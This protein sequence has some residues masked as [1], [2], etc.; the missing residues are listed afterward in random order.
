[1]PTYPEQSSASI[2]IDASPD[3]VWNL[4][5]DIT[6][7]GEYSP[8][9]YKTEW[10]DGASGPAVGAHFHGYNR[11]G[12]FEWDVAGIVTE[13]EAGKVFEFS[14]PRGSDTPT[15]WRY[16]IA[17]SGSGTTL[18]ES[19]DAPLL[20]VEGSPANF[21]GRYEMMSEA[22]TTTLANIKATAEG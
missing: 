18:S 19:F 5:S 14:V 16:E 20:N 17:P 2:D 9:C 15:T 7:M 22:I 3:V 12:T 11:Q 4:V 13:C 6:R 8:E 1:M 10:E 21:E